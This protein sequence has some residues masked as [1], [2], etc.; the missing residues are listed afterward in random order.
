VKTAFCY[1]STA[2]VAPADTLKDRY[3]KTLGGS[4]STQEHEMEEMKPLCHSQTGYKVTIVTYSIKL[5]VD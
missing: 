4:R 3:N 5:Q 2:A 1:K